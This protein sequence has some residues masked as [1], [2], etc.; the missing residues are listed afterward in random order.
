MGATP[1]RPGAEAVAAVAA[2]EGLGRASIV[3]TSVASSIGEGGVWAVVASSAA[4][5]VRGGQRGTTTPRAC[6]LARCFPT[7]VPAVTVTTLFH[8]PAGACAC[9]AREEGQRTALLRLSR[10]LA[11]WNPAIPHCT[12]LSPRA[13]S[14]AGVA[15]ALHTPLAE[16]HFSMQL[17]P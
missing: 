17:S 14:L 3:A 1:E 5:V 16:Q 2:C 10:P 13:A 4:G 8:A 12:A 7:C 6:D 11:P 15:S 9:R